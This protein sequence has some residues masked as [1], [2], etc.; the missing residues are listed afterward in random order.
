MLN[1]DIIGKVILIGIVVIVIGIIIVVG[2]VK[3]V[4][5]VEYASL[6]PPDASPSEVVEK[7]A[8]WHG[9]GNFEAC[10]DFL[11]SREYRNSTDESTFKET[12][13]QCKPAFS[14]YEFIEVKSEKIDGDSASVEVGYLEKYD[15]PLLGDR[16][17]LHEIT[18][19]SKTKTINLVKEEEGWRLTDIHCELKG[20]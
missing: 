16:N 7:F 2:V 1:D 15:D 17:P 12:M 11:M 5:Y 19:K 4:E 3:L 18:Q 13:R 6:P 14:H 9:G 20:K 8:S 10:Y